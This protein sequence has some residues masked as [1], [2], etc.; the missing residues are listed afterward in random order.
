[1]RIIYFLIF[2][3]IFGLSPIFVN[4]SLAVSST[5]TSD[6]C[7]LANPLG[8]VTEVPVL[9]GTIVKGVLGIVGALALFFF[10]WGGFA[11]MTSA[12]NPEKVKKGRDTLMWAS[13]GLIA[14]FASYSLLKFILD[15]LTRKI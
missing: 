7:T 14:T 5:C 1:M 10:F 13:I 15:M 4:D 6:K 2:F 12:G 11:W 9:I 8:N 3:L